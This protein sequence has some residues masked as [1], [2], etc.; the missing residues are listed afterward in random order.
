MPMIKARSFA[1]YLDRRV[2]MVVALGFASGL[3]LLLTFSTL[4]A[5]LKDSGISRA[6]IGMFALVGIPYSFKF[7]WSPLIDRLTLPVLT[8]YFGRRRGWGLFLQTL[9]ILAVLA[10]ANCDPSADLGRMAMLAVLVAFLSASQDI[11]ID[12]YRVEI[13]TED[14]QGPGAGAVQL[15][16][17]A[18]MMAAGAG[19]L[20]IASAFGWMA[21]YMAM[22]ALLACGLLVFL[23]G[24]EPDAKVNPAVAALEQAASQYL[25][26]R[27]HLQGRRAAIISWLYGAV[28]GPFAEFTTRRGWVAILLLV[29][30]Y[31][32]GE[33]M[34]GATANVFYLE[35]GYSLDEIATISKV[36]GVGPTIL[37]SVIG[38]AMVVRLGAV[39]AMLIFGVLQS[40]GNLFYVVQA[41]A[42]HNLWAL[43]LCV[44]VENFTAGLAGSALVAYVSGLCNI[45]YTATQYALLSSL[46][47]LGRTLFASSSG[48]LADWLGW[49]DFYLLTTAITIPALLLLL[50]IDRSNHLQTQ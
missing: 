21:A 31:K 10:L 43:A 36:F 16:Y 3:P 28:I 14:Q 25:Q 26:A 23:L 45:A 30:G 49:T 13:L 7:V 24:P 50:W 27:P 46:S 20:F 11:V 22:A 5:W 29:I 39:R 48:T 40:L 15:G 4:S 8:A 19:A 33:A 2:L 6:A 32:M 35:L 18:G 37:G 12:A 34:A 9:L 44:S 38:G 47:S 42:G 17:R 41:M 1:A